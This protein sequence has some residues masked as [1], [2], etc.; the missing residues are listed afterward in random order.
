MINDTAL[1]SGID[2]FRSGRSQQLVQA[3]QI[4]LI[5][6]RNVWTGSHFNSTCGCNQCTPCNQWSSKEECEQSGCTAVGAHGSC[7]SHVLT[8]VHKSNI[9]A[10]F[11]TGNV[12]ASMKTGLRN[13]ENRLKEC[14]PLKKHTHQKTTPKA[15]NPHPP[16]E[17]TWLLYRGHA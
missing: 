4:S 3:L 8:G 9:C 7:T 6:S 2:H 1:K 12:T 14:R 15:T 16:E 11:Q 10:I 13:R 5:I 17:G